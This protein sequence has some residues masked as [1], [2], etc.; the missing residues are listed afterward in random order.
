MENVIGRIGPLV[1][2]II[3]SIMMWGVPRIAAITQNPLFRDI[4]EIIGTLLAIVT[5]VWMVLQIDTWFKK[6]KNSKK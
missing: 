6:R 5:I 2:S 3:S 4:S 1:S